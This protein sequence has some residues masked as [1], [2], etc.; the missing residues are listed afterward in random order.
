MA[1]DINVI[2]K[3]FHDKFGGPYLK[4]EP[5]PN[6]GSNRHY[7]RLTAANNSTVLAVHNEDVSENKAYLAFSQTFA[8]AG[9]N[10]PEVL[11][12]DN[13]FKYYLVEDIG[14]ETLY[15][16]VT[17]AD[18]K[19]DK[20]LI[21]LYSRVLDD[22][23]HIQINAGKDINYKLCIGSPCFD[24]M[25]IKWDLNY[26]KYCYLKL[27]HISFDEQKLENDFETIQQAVSEADNQYF[28]FRDFQSRNIMIKDGT[29]YYID[30][31]GGKRGPLVYDVASLLYQ[32]KAKLS[33]ETRDLLF[34]KYIES[35]QRLIAVDKEKMYKEFKIFALVRTLQVLGAYGFRGY[36]E[37]KR[38]FVESIPFALKNLKNLLSLNLI[39]LPHLCEIA[40]T[41]EIAEPAT[42]DYQGLTVT[43]VSFS[44][45]KGIP[46]DAET[47][48][49]F[50]FDCRGQHNPGRYDEYKMLTGRDKP[51]I[52]FLKANSTIDVFLKQAVGIV[53]PT[54]EK[55]IERGFT[56]LMVCFGCTG[57]QHR[58]VYCA[59]N[60]AEQISAKHNVRIKLI[61]RE[62]GL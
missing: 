19:P 6:S 26:F 61:H 14:R 1:F 49:G 23:A 33:E 11:A 12:H 57:G 10:V 54:I 41:I 20:P 50:V 8:D 30:F 60:F 58:S 24:Q 38:H 28:M 52:D 29:P 40:D 3:L 42:D 34:G 48:G 27:A 44:Y 16:L 4:C 9:I 56:K 35:V 46:T 32:A 2:N 13:S 62:L 53:E 25:A 17:A 7:Y 51:V 37:R 18:G 21:A 39:K 31:Q 36:Y 45:K 59:Q 55:Y 47:G 15:E 22:L 5:M 43:V